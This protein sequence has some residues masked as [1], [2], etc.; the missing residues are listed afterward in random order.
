MAEGSA[1]P[2]DTERTGQES[3]VIPAGAQ[4]FEPHLVTPSPAELCMKSFQRAARQLANI[5][6]VRA[7]A[8]RTRRRERVKT[9]RCVKVA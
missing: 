7:K 9:I 3:M 5:R 8:A 4:D 1:R 2:P 6:L